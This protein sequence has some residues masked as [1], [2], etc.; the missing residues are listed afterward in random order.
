MN[1]TLLTD[2]EGDAA[3]AKRVAQHNAELEADA[4]TLDTTQYLEHVLSKAVDTW[5]REDY[6]ENVKRL[7][8]AAS[9]LSYQERQA[10]IQ[11]IENRTQAE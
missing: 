6:E 7:G 8:A 9:R 4:P 11:D 5:K 2:P 10:L 3:I 1:I